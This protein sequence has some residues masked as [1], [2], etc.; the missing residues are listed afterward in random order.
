MRRFL[1]QENIHQLTTQ[2]FYK[3]IGDCEKGLAAVYNALKN[4]NIYHPLDENRR[5]DI[6]VEG[7]KD[8]KQFDN[9]A[10]K[11]TFNDSYGTV[12]GKWSAL[13]TGVFRANQVLA[14]IEKIRPNVTDE[15]QI[16]KLAQIEH[17]HILCV[18]CF[19]FISIIHSIMVMFLILMKLQR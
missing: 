19:I 11:Q 8:R 6:A 2:N 3:T 12:R 18:A 16:T 14:S 15:P 4:T 5:S 10:Y 9:E 13:Y 17:R 7:N 1:T